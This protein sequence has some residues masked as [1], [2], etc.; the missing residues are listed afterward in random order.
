MS[1]LKE[2]VRYGRPEKGFP[3]PWNFC[4]VASWLGTALALLCERSCTASSERHLSCPVVGEI[5]CRVQAWQ[6]GEAFDLL[7]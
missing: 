7:R 4:A 6:S 5:K 2:S 1:P 3:K